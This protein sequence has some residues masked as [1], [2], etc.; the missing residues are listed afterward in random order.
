MSVVLNFGHI[1]GERSIAFLQEKL[2]AFDYVHQRLKIDF[3]RPISEQVVE[4][5]NAAEAGCKR[6]LLEAY[7]G[8]T[9]IYLVPPGLTDPTIL[10]LI[11]L[12]GR[13]GAF[14]NLLLMRRDSGEYVIY[15]IADGE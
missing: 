9:E 11:E 7:G 14:P 13:T 4:A 5:V 12:F 15:D 8:G 2:G 3:D 10:L 1:L 6:G